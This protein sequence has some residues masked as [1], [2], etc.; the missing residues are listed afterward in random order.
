MKDLSEESSVRAQMLRNYGE[1]EKG[2]GKLGDEQVRDGA[3]YNDNRNFAPT[4][5][6]LEA[7]A[8]KLYAQRHADGPAD[9]R[10][11]L[12]HRP[13]FQPPCNR[14]WTGPFCQ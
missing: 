3:Y 9:G 11:P 1:V 14:A 2:R 5:D 7:A 13:Q 4:M 8:Q 6:V 10:Q 12:S